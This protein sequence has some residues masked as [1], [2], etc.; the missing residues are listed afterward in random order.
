VDIPPRGR[1]FLEH[2]VVVAPLQWGP[3]GFKGAGVAVGV[4]CCK[5]VCLSA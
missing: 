5:A 3:G 2:H 4:G 1:P